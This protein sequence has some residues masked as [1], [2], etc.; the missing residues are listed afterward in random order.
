MYEH[1]VNV[2]NNVQIIINIASHAGNVSEIRK[3]NYLYHY[4]LIFD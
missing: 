1:I 4:Q 3:T 2:K